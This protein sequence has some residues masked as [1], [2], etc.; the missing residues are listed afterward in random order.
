MIDQL[1]EDLQRDEGWR[2]EPYRCSEGFL[3]IG[4]G[5]LIDEH[6]SIRMPRQVG[7]L[8][9][10][11]IVQERWEQLIDAEP[12]LVDQAEAVQRAVGNMAYQLGVN[13]VLRFKNMLAALRSGDRE[14]AATAAMDSRWALQ[15]PDRAQ[16]VANLIRG[17]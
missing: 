11:L 5:F 3:T 13:G 10:E 1:V 7:H 6:R 9:L 8:W 16:R 12:W 4:Y 17:G 2:D 15:T 14:G